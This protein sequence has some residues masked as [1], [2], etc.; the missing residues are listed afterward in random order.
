MNEKIKRFFENDAARLL[1]GA[2]FFAVAV[3]FELT[4]LDILSVV[5][6]IV[7]LLLSG[8]PVFLSAVK[9]IFRRDFFDEKFLMSIASIGA[10]IIGDMSE[11]VAVMLFF[12]LGEIFEKKA[13]RKSRSSIKSLINIRPDEANVIIDGEETVLLAEDVSLGSE[14]IIRAGERVPIDSLVI[15]GSADVDTSMLTGESVPR[16]VSEGDRIESGSIVL[17]GILRARTEKIAEE[18]SA[19]RILELVENATENKAREE[20]FITVFSRFYT[21]IVVGLALLI[22]VFLPLIADKITYTES[23]YRA[24]TFL[25]ISCPCA[26]VI[27]V[28]MA[29]F[30]GIGGAAASGILFKGGNVFSPLSKADTF[31]FDKTGTV[32]TGKIKVE[33]V[34]P[35]GTSENE[36]CFYAASAEYGSTHPISTAIKELSKN[37]A[38]PEKS[39]VIA[40]KGVAATVLGK[41][42][43]VGNRALLSEYGVS[44]P[45]DFEDGALVSIDGAFSGVIIFGDALKPE[46][47]KA[48]LDLRAQGAKRLSMLSGDKSEKAKAVAN[49]VGF[50]EAYGNLLPEDKYEKLTEIINSS[51]KTAFVGD[52]INDAPSLAL[53]DVGIAMG[54]MGSDSA[55]EAAD[56]VIMNDNLTK[57]PL[58]KKIARRT[59]G[60][61]KQN[62]IFAIGVKALVLL[63]GALGYADMWL[64]VFADVGVAVIAILNAMRALRVKK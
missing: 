40:G 62:I 49:A 47:Q 10:V 14:I 53:A 24:L 16:S 50:D 57:I 17:N 29:F 3:I 61:A 64:A 42:V 36:L 19:Q 33:R 39:R 37:P 44:L 60:I 41:E 20:K 15:Y 30:G 58:S 28:P 13:V 26:L 38:V 25:V 5:G 11:G 8:A 51:A 35:H 22:A 34:V 12:L 7:A 9:G 45:E 31:V 52:G 2:L 21:P 55:I 48:L 46:A 4:E 18:S 27:S 43:L 56:V 54:G 32:T 1:F 6:Y 59:L 23:V 63:L